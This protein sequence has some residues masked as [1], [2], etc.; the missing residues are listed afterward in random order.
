MF[1]EWTVTFTY[2]LFQ[3]HFSTERVREKERAERRKCSNEKEAIFGLHR[4]L[5]LYHRLSSSPPPT[6]CSPYWLDDSDLLLFF[7]SSFFFFNKFIMITLVLRET[8]C[9]VIWHAKFF[10]LF[11]FFDFV[12]WTVFSSFL[13]SVRRNQER[14][15]EKE[16]KKEREKINLIVNFRV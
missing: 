15:W 16:I 13:F 12:G 4:L 1:G 9:F 8:L 11:K 10:L 2:L 6:T 3:I 7:F 5:N 14:V